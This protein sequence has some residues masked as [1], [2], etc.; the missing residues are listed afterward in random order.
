MGQKDG[1]GGLGGERRRALWPGGRRQE[2]QSHFFSPGPFLKTKI[3][4]PHL[5]SVMPIVSGLLK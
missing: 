2:A 5:P 1:V 4:K 3:V